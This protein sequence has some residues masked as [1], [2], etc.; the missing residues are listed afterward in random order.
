VP[1]R[2]DFLRPDAT[3]EAPPPSSSI[4][5]LLNLSVTEIAIM[6]LLHQ[7]TLLPRSQQ[8][9]A[10]AI[11]EFY[12]VALSAIS[13]AGSLRDAKQSDLRLIYF[14]GLIVAQTHPRSQ[15][16]DAIREADHALDHAKTSNEPLEPAAPQPTPEPPVT[17]QDTLAHIADALERPPESSH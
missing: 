14:K 7:R 2:T 16:I 12:P 6:W 4:N 5:E 13:R 15:M 10:S 3:R 1:R 11:V 9:L 17:D 8:L